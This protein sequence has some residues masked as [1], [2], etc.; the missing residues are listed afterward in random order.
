MVYARPTSHGIWKPFYYQIGIAAG[1]GASYRV[2]CLFVHHTF[3]LELSAALSLWGPEFTGKMKVKWWIISFTIKFGS[4]NSG[5][6]YLTFEEFL[7]Q[8]VPGD[9]KQGK[10]VRRTAAQVKIMPRSQ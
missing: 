2:D 10:P 7:E 6:K 9:A 8:C 4:G 3:T 1:I 5:I